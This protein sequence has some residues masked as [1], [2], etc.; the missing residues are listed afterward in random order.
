MTE[1]R[2]QWGRAPWTRPLYSFHRGD[3]PSCP[4][5]AIVGGGL[6]GVSTAYHLASKGARTVLLE[7]GLIGDG[8]SG[9]TGGLV[10]EG[11]AAGILDQVDKCVPGLRS[12]VEREEIDCELS[13]PGCWEIAH[14]KNGRHA[15]PWIDDGQPI[16]IASS[17]SGGVVQPAALTIGI[18]KAAERRGAMLFED[19]PASQ[20]KLK[21]EL[22]LEVDGE[23]IFPKCIVIAT[24]AWINA[25]LPE[26]PPLHSSLTYACITAPLAAA[27][28]VTLGVRERIPFY[29]KDLPYLWGR[30][31]SDGRM[32]FGAGLTFGSPESL[33]NCDLRDNS[34]ATTLTRLCRRVSALHPVLGRTRIEASWGGPIAFT[35]S[36]VPLLGSHPANPR[37][38]ISGGYAGHG[39]AL[40]VRA[41]ELI[42]SSI[43]DNHPLPEWGKLSR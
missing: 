40:S 17:V 7:A 11:T 28:L 13:L 5:V 10:L 1:L 12:I 6:T 43:N 42:A 30:N 38:L 27:D 35:D 3:V 29:T 8:A 19:A 25:T 21:G 32:I 2:R 14:Q 24:N 39:V 15:L 33:E 34:V 20:L 16:A 37:V 23:K 41:G 9:R 18:A 22:Y 4:D 31:V 36:I 26:T